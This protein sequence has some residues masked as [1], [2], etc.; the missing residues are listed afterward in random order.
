M[1]SNVGQAHSYLKLMGWWCWSLTK[2]N[3]IVDRDRIQIKTFNK[4]SEEY[5]MYPFSSVNIQGVEGVKWSGQSFQPE[6]F[7]ILFLKF[8][9]LKVYLRSVLTY[10]R[11]EADDAADQPDQED[12]EVHPGLCPL[13]RIVDGVMDGFV[14]E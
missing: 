14:P 12:H 3:I 7:F 2:V 11:W 10:E 4:P 9:S 1:E 13:G 8:L 5:T 6:I